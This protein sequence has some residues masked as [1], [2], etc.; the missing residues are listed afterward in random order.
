MFINGILRNQC[1]KDKNVNTLSD[2]MQAKKEPDKIEARYIKGVGPKMA[3]IFMKVGIRTVADLLYY[4][5]RRYED[6]SNIVPLNEL[7]ASSEQGVIGVVDKV[8]SFTARTGRRILTVV[9]TD[10]QTRLYAVWYNQPYLKDKFSK[11]DRVLFYGKVERK[12]RYEMTH[13]TFEV[14]RS[15]DKDLRSLNMGRI[16]PIY[17][18][19]RDLNQKYLRSVIYRAVRSYSSKLT[20]VLPTAVRARNKL[21]DIK[22]AIE[23]IHFPYS[24]ENLKRAYHRMVF[25]EFFLL[26]IIMA[27]KRKKTRKKG[28]IHKV[29]ADTKKRFVSFFDFKLT[30]HQKKAM[31]AVDRDMTSDKPM[32][33]LIQGDVGSGKTVVAMYALYLC[34]EGGRQGVIMVPT[35]ILAR[36]HYLNISKVFMPLGYNVRF[37]SGKLSPKIKRHIMKEISSGEVDIVVGTHAAFQKG[38]E[39]KNLGLAII[40]EQHKFGVE[41]R[42]K[43]REKG[44][45]TDTL[46][47]TATP[48]PRSLALTLFGD[49]D[50]SVI[51]EKPEGRQRVTTWFVD[52]KDKKAAYEFVREEVSHGNQAFIVC[53][54]IRETESSE[55]SSAESLY[56]DLSQG[57]FQDLKVAL[58]HG[59][60]DTE[61]RKN[62]M[63]KFRSGKYAVLIATTVI[64]VGVDI[65]NATVMVIEDADRYGLAQLHQLRG[66]IGRG[67]ENS[68]CVVLSSSEEE[69]VKKRL[70]GFCESED[71]FQIA[72]Q[73]MDQRGPGELLGTRQSG[74]PEMKFADLRTDLIVMERAREE[75]F[76]V[77]AEDIGLREDKNAAIANEI[78]RKFHEG[79]LS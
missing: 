42:K 3:E 12:G 58:L 25:E 43:L 11:G 30:E 21:V 67:K 65:P 19:T 18:L 61:D 55:L 37:Y 70:E 64:E 16:V 33:R 57:I 46:I 48:I 6:R 17:P 29:S 52:S 76:K 5:P 53:P 2:F 71:G 23:N 72:E 40:D 44:K 45:M 9:V 14:I 54:R 27:L 60:M 34:V 26:Q 36:Q 78:K 20:D 1:R 31:R 66:R 56:R 59:R 69:K 4:L 49:M 10:R 68:Y 62:V 74:L 47:I 50:V 39:Y 24:F 79:V 73:D 38:A 22:F 51:K 41:Q 32:Y 28:L 15:E 75:A 63:E 35:E 8:S 77:V 13:P 7:V